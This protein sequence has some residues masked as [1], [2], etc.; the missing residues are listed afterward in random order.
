MTDIP[1]MQSSGSAVGEMP[2][3]PRAHSIL[4]QGDKS[5]VISIK[6]AIGVNEQCLDSASVANGIASVNAS[7]GALDKD[8]E[9][10][11]INKTL[12]TAVAAAPTAVA[13]ASETHKMGDLS[14]EIANGGKIEKNEQGPDGLEDTNV[15][16]NVGS[17]DNAVNSNITNTEVGEFLKAS[18]GDDE[19]AAASTVPQDGVRSQTPVTAYNIEKLVNDTIII[20]IKN[21][22]EELVNEIA[23]N[24][25]R[26]EAMQTLFNYLYKKKC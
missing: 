7:E 10:N 18:N 13:A 20:H 12:P 25:Q 3:S 5:S 4:A 15:P 24:K 6:G 11:E 9:I 19:M 1:N 23:R 22:N 16:M 2:S 8:S 14:P 21:L 17:S 26:D